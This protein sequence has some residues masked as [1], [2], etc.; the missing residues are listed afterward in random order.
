MHDFLVESN[1]CIINIAFNPPTE[2]T[3]ITDCDF[4]ASDDDV[5]CKPNQL[6][7]RVH[8]SELVSISH[9]EVASD[10]WKDEFHED[11]AIHSTPTK[12]SVKCCKMS[13]QWHQNKMQQE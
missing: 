10:R 4:D 7:R 11:I 3:I 13:L 6:W 5:M 2:H 8:S 9:N 12:P 1:D